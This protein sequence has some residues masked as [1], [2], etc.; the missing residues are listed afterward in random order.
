VDI[1]GAKIGELDRVGEQV[2]E[3]LSYPEWV[4]S[5]QTVQRERGERGE[6]GEK[7][8]ERGGE[9][10]ERGERIIKKLA[11]KD[12]PRSVAD[13]MM[14]SLGGVVH[15]KVDI[16]LFSL[17]GQNFHRFV[18]NRAKTKRYLIQFY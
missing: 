18:D 5:A 2:G 16:L 11:R 1:D 7:R 6:R 14:G 3:H 15:V 13:V 12:I 10:G 4:P 9:R 8:G 17:Y